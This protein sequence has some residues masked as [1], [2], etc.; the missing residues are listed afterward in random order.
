MTALS[1]AS[2]STTVTTPV[3]SVAMG[4]VNL[5]GVD[6]RLMHILQ[7]VHNHGS[8][9]IHFNFGDAGK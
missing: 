1:Q 3:S 7:N 2:S 8:L 5:A 4:L 9:Q 6:P